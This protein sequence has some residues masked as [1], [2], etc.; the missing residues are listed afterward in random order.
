MSEKETSHQ[1]AA[2][3]SE[4][5]AALESELARL[6]GHRKRARARGAVAF[7]TLAA[8]LLAAGLA[9]SQED[10]C[11]DAVPNCFASGDT[12]KADLF[13]ENFAALADALDSLAGELDSKVEQSEEGDVEVPG[14]L[15]MPIYAKSCEASSGE[16]RC[17]CD[18]NEFAL[19]GGASAPNYGNLVQSRPDPDNAWLVRCTNSSGQDAACTKVWTVCAKIRPVE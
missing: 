2:G 13:N 5:M 15:S 3:I 18:N 8:C 11:S 17:A 19:S 16:T 7:A 12:V 6:I 9:T 14:W 4:R 1:D 10:G